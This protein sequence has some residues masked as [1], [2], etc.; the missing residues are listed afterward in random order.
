V[1]IYDVV[2]VTAAYDATPADARWNPLADLTTPWNKI[3]IFD[4]VVVTHV[5]GRT[6]TP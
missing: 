1:N 2:T 6:W 4:V 3:S 5:Y